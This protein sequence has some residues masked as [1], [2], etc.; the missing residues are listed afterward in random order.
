VHDRWRDEMRPVEHLDACSTSHRRLLAG[1][2]ALTDDDVRSASL[3]PGYSRGHVVTHLA[4]KAKAHVV[5]FEGAAVRQGIMTADPRT[6]VEIL[7][8][9]LRNVEVH[10]VDLD[11][12]YGISAWPA[13]FVAGELS[14]RLRALPHRAD[15]AELLAWLLGRAPAPHLAGPW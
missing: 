3:L 11:I 5:V 1:L 8:H 10:H 13:A 2:A 4:E 7:A 14:K 15:H 6:M 9:H 12:G